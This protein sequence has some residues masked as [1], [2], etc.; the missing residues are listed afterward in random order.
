V[1]EPE[2]ERRP[3]GQILVTLPDGP[4]VCWHVVN[5]LEDATMQV[6]CR[7]HPVVIGRLYRDRSVWWTPDPSLYPTSTRRRGDVAC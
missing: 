2:R 1:D 3:G 4:M 5:I 6:G 7:E